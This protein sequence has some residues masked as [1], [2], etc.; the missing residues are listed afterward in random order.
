MEEFVETYVEAVEEFRLFQNH[1]AD[2]L[3]GCS[4]NDDLSLVLQSYEKADTHYKEA[5]RLLARL[6]LRFCRKTEGRNPTNWTQRERESYIQTTSLSDMLSRGMNNLL[7]VHK[8][9]LRRDQDIKL[10]AMR[11]AGSAS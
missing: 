7:A 5:T 1:A 8:I 6:S 10:A 11:L 4:V 2:V 9:S 3:R